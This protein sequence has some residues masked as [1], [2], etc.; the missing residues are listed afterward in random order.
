MIAS[1]RQ[2]VDYQILT[3]S[4]WE[5]YA[6]L[7]SGNGM[8]LEQYGPY[9]LVRPAA[10]AMW[11]AALPQ[12]EWQTA[13][14]IFQP[15]GG[16][17]GGQWR[18]RKT[19]LPEFWQMSYR[20]LRFRVFTGASRHVGVFVEQSPQW[21]WIMETVQSAGQPLQVLNL[22]AYSGLATLA[23]AAA[24]AKVT[25]LDA[26]KKSVQL[27]RQNQ[28]LSGLA[29]KPI[30]WIVDDALKF[31]KREIRRGVR[32]DGI[33]LDPPKFGRGPKGEV[34]EF[35]DLLPNLLEL[36]RQA[37]SSRPRFFVLTAYAIQA[38][39]LSLFYMVQDILSLRGGELSCGELTLAE[40][41][42]GRLL[43]MAIF[44]RWRA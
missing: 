42:A 8:R 34:W 25:H 19:P 2:T 17:S 30:R 26:S 28:S 40:K 41:S 12:E 22:F 18:Y 10:Q 16:E 36:C 33:I 43:P 15:S 44:T 38:S 27:A 6:L 31:L 4:G 29:E 3:A 14:A 37:L 23:A 39:A 21:D 7:D 35:F 13:D 9:R 1:K 32:Y 5:D 11:R 20:H 24:G